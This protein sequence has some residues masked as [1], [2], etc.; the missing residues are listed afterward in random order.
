MQTRLR[1]SGKTDF[2]S[3]AARNIAS[4][5]VNLVNS[6]HESWLNFLTGVQDGGKVRAE[7][8]RLKRFEES[9]KVYETTVRSLAQ[10]VSQLRALSKMPN[11]GRQRVSARIT[12]Y[13]PYENR[14]T[15]SLNDPKDIVPGMAVLAPEGL[16]GIVQTVSGNSCQALTIT[17]PTAR[18]GAMVLEDIPVPGLIKGQTPTRLVLDVLDSATIRVGDSVVTSGYSD[19]I[20]RGIPIGTVAEVVLDQ[21]FGT[22]RVFVAPNVEMGKNIDVWVVK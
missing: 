7:L 5:G 2:V 3:Q 16:I 12:G 8:Q 10:E 17:S 1:N 22:R 15:L 20:P 21:S 19:K 13:F 18:Y 6:V 14:L 11:F 9:A 4:P